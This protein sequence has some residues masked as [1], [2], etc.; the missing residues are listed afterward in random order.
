MHSWIPHVCVFMRWNHITQKAEFVQT[1]VHS[2]APSLNL[3][4]MYNQFFCFGWTREEK[5]PIG[6]FFAV[7]VLLGRFPSLS[8]LEIQQD[9]G[10]IYK[11]GVVTGKVTPVEQSLVLVTTQ[12]F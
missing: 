3:K 2:S 1:G 11:M 9:R 12:N 10:N 7:C 6:L 8:V 5:I 4:C